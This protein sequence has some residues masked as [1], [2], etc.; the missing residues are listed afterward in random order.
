MPHVLSVLSL[1]GPVTKQE[2]HHKISSILNNLID[3]GRFSWVPPSGVVSSNLRGGV[4][5]G[6]FKEIKERHKYVLQKSRFDS[7]Q[8]HANLNP[9]S[10]IYFELCCH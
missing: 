7:L 1:V 8:L 3:T 9:T 6:I 4:I 10:S 5:A 2:L